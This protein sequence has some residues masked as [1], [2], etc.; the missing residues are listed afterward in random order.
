MEQ[1]ARIFPQ[2]LRTSRR[3]HIQIGATFRHTTAGATR[4]IVRS[5]MSAAILPESD[6][7][8]AALVGAEQA[9]WP[10]DWSAFRAF[11]AARPSAT[12]AHVA[13]LHLAFSVLR[14][15]DD[16]TASLAVRLRQLSLSTG[17]V[18]G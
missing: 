10:Q 3:R 1:G 15:V 17:R 8:L 13:D 2:G 16:A 7:V 5:A 12:V 6:A 9:A 14:N 18:I 4:S 11:V